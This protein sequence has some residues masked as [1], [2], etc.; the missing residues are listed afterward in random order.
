MQLFW[1]NV[2]DILGKPQNK[3][4]TVLIGPTS[5]RRNSPYENLLLITHNAQINAM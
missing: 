3:V 2:P 1:N 4:S 5:H